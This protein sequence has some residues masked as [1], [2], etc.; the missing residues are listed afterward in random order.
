MAET[1]SA[2]G[3]TR[4]ASVSRLTVLGSAGTARAPRILIER[5]PPRVLVTDLMLAALARALAPADSTPGPDADIFAR[6]HTPATHARARTTLCAEWPRLRTATTAALAAADPAA[7][8]RLAHYLQSTA[9]L[10]DD[11]ALLELCARLSATAASG[12]AENSRALLA[13]VDSHLAAWPH[14]PSPS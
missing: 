14:P 10:L 12:S 13:A 9:L 2:S 1:A 3:A 5:T 8:R 4:C 11:S 6:L 7:L